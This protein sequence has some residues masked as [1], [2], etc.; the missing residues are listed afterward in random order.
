VDFSSKAVKDYINYKARVLKY[1]FPDFYREVDGFWVYGPTETKGFLS[2]ADLTMLAKL[3]TEANRA[4]ENELIEFF[5]Q[6]PWGN[7]RSV[8][9]GDF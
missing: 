5:A 9:I 8:T 3:L 2:A 7:E 1:A 6:D 4:W